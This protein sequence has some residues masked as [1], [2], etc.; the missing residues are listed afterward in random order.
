MSDPTEAVVAALVQLHEALVAA[1]PDVQREQ[2]GYVVVVNPSPHPDHP[3]A[4]GAY[5][6][7]VARLLFTDRRDQPDGQPPLYDLRMHVRPI[8]RE[9]RGE[10]ADQVV[11]ARFEVTGTAAPEVPDTPHMVQALLP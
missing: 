7:P 5:K 2:V 8:Y 3:P 4:L 11:G 1:R 10:P 6:A 9:G